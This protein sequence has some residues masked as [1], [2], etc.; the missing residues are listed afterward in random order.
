MPN[1]PIRLEY[2]PT[3]T[4]TKEQPKND[5]SNN[6]GVIDIKAVEIKDNPNNLESLENKN[7]EKLIPVEELLIQKK[8]LFWKEYDTEMSKNGIVDDKFYRDLLD[9][10][11]LKK[12]SN[13]DLQFTTLFANEYKEKYIKQQNNANISDLV[14]VENIETKTANQSS[15]QKTDSRETPIIAAQ[16]EGFV[17]RGINAI[18]E[19]FKKGVKKI[20]TGKI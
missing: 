8:E 19:L 20:N 15:E 13:G 16:K 11:N 5:T 18:R 9:K 17:N 12:M 6:E 4:D 14:K 1:S 2:T 7:T 3:S 10:Y